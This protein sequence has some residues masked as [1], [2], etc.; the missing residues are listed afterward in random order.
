VVHLALVDRL[1]LGDLD[2]NCVEISRTMRLG[3]E[4]ERGLQRLEVGRAAW[5]PTAGALVGAAMR[6]RDLEIEQA[7]RRR[8]ETERRHGR[9]PRRLHDAAKGHPDRSFYLVQRCDRV[10]VRCRGNLHVE[11][12]SAVA[13]MRPT[14]EQEVEKRESPRKRLRSFRN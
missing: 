14:V 7:D 12:L 10:V 1:N 8:R 4:R 2:L 3:G 13:G 11:C 9:E 5:L 6:R